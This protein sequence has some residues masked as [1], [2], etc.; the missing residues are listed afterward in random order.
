MRRLRSNTTITDEASERV[1]EIFDTTQPPDSATGTPPLLS[2]I[3]ERSAAKSRS[4][5]RD[6]TEA[7]A[8]ESEARTRTGAATLTHDA[9]HATT[10]ESRE[11]TEARSR[12]RRDDPRWLTWMKIAGFL[13][14]G[15]FMLWLLRTVCKAIKQFSNKH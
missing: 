10:T 2:R 14:A 9:D 13:A 5:S 11:A 7:T 6:Q 12:E 15:G 4:E 8:A 1:T 3:T